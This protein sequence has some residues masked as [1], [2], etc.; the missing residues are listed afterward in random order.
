MAVGVGGVP[1][2]VAVAVGEGVAVAVAVA[3]VV[4][5][6]VGVTVDGAPTKK[7]WLVVCPSKSTSN[8]H[9]PMGTPAGKLNVHHQ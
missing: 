5:V 2:T 4:G 3:V 8:R 6:G 9:V 1:I 7:S